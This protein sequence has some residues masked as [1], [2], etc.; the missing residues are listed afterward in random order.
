MIRLVYTIDM[1][2]KSIF[3]KIVDGEIP[4]KKIY[5]DDYTLAF[6]DIMP[7]TPG[8]VLV[9]PKRQVEFV[10]DLTD[11]E[12]TA[13]MATVKKVAIHIRQ[14]L[15]P[16]YVGQLIVG[17]DV[18]HAHVHVVPFEESRQ[19]KEALSAV[20]ERMDDAELDRIAETLKF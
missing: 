16:S 12:Y 5:E 8:H 18:P 9:I 6:L 19:L 7:A 20:R 13:V 17:T 10:W 2:E 11:Q 3:A 1:T 4:C 14:V 15:S